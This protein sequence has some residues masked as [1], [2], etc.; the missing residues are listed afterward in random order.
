M[1]A[2]DYVRNLYL[3]FLGR[4]PDDG[5]HIYWINDCRN[6]LRRT[7]LSLALSQEAQDPDAATS[8]YNKQKFAQALYRAILVREPSQQEIQNTMAADDQT[9]STRTNIVN[10]FLNSTEFRNKYK[11]F[12]CSF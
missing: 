4:E 10:G 5:G 6:N 1:Y 12:E 7:T 3:N 11:T 9:I 8:V 2:N